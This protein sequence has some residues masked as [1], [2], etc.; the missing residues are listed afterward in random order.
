MKKI[1]LTLLIF[2]FSVNFVFAQQNVSENE[3]ITVTGKVTL[4]SID[5]SWIVIKIENTLMSKVWNSLKSIFWRRSENEN[6]YRVNI[7]DTTILE[8]SDGESVSLDNVLIGDSATVTGVLVEKIDEDKSGLIEASYIKIYHPKSVATIITEFFSFTRTRSL[9]PGDGDKASLNQNKLPVISQWLDDYQDCVGEGEPI[10]EPTLFA[11]KVNKECCEGLT[12]CLIDGYNSVTIGGLQYII[13]GYCREECLESDY[14]QNNFER[15]VPFKDPMKYLL[16]QFPEQPIKHTKSCVRDSDCSSSQK[17]INGRCVNNISVENNKYCVKNEDCVFNGSECISK[18]TSNF[19]WFLSNQKSH[20]ACVNNMCQYVP[21]SVEETKPSSEIECGSEV[22]KVCGEDNKTYR[23]PCEAFKA[24]VKI[25]CN[26][27]CPCNEDTKPGDVMKCSN[28]SDCVWCNDNCY[29]EDM[30]EL[31]NMECDVNKR[32][33]KDASCICDEEE[34]MCKL[35]EQEDDL[36]P[37]A[38]IFDPT[39]PEVPD[40]ICAKDNECVFCGPECVTKSVL[41]NILDSGS[42]CNSSLQPKNMKCVCRNS[43]CVTEKI[44]EPTTS[45]TTSTLP[46]PREEDGL[47]KNGVG[48][49]EDILVNGFCGQQTNGIC[50]KDSD[51]IVGGCSG[52][53]CQS[54]SEPNVITTC[55]W[56]GCYHKPNNVY[57]GCNAGRCQWYSAKDVTETVITE[58]PNSPLI[59]PPTT[60]PMI[61]Y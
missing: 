10:L 46:L 34:K 36:P 48:N 60:L 6:A 59:V 42:S 43:V 5:D 31:H 29:T 27:P 30:I 54:K 14:Q 61:I 25:Q 45:T 32:I 53:V 56:R 47:P 49:L 15:T 13:K 24:G 38:P 41:N 58:N 23:N 52:T 21:I 28:S 33:P 44:Q 51:C 16:P 11:P 57:C 7:L 40:H 1:L 22:F 35:K 12:P 18:N 26:K 19:V 55:D 50:T 2:V 37:I 4:V 3:K 39:E 20:C 8:A 17:C 9:D